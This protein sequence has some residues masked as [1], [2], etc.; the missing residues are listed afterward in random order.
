MTPPLTRNHALG[1]RKSAVPAIAAFTLVE[2][3]VVIAIIGVLVALLLPAVQ[4]AREAA[5][6]S[7]CQN[8]LKQLSLACLNHHDS[9][10]HFPG[11]GW[12]WRWG[13]DPDRGSGAQQ[14]GS[15][16]YSALPY[17][18]LRALHQLGSDGQPATLTPAQLDGASRRTMTPVSIINCPSRRPAA[19]FAENPAGNL[20]FPE[21]NANRDIVTAMVR[22]DYAGN[23]G[24]VD[25]VQWGENPGSWPA[26]GK[27]TPPTPSDDN[28]LVLGVFHNSSEVTI[29]QIG[30]GTSNTYLIG[31][32]YC[33][34][35]AYEDGRDYT[36][37]ESAYSGN[38]DDVLR[39]TSVEAIQDLYDTIQ[40][41]RFGSAHS[42][43]WYVAMCDGS[44][45]GI[46][47]DIDPQVH[48]DYG[49]RDGSGAKAAVPVPPPPR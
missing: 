38:N 46:S 20:Q 35:V 5:R 16:L 26:G 13:G 12:G 24:A 43:V 30:D 10:G 19:L 9:K 44:V 42:A 40:Q 23:A 21:L 29:A 8:H 48:L 37:T 17:V 49:T 45:Q 34:V 36:D 18:E 27:R 41:Q 7:Q 6:R 25:N 28:A 32:K 47:Y 4:A 39:R 31:E 11:G 14:P 15:W 2:L 22:S 3:L 33:A 1:R